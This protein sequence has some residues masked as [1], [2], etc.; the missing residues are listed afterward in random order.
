MLPTVVPD[1]QVIVPEKVP[2][3]ETDVTP[4]PLRGLQL[5]FGLYP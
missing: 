3:D 5:L 2:V 1:G 4:P